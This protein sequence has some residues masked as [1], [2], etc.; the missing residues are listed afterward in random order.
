MSNRKRNLGINVRVTEQ[1]KKRITRNA[2]RCG[3]SSS[4]YLR[5]L[6]SCHSPKAIPTPEIREACRMLSELVSD[7]AANY[8]DAEFQG[9]L[10]Y[11]LG[12]LLAFC[13]PKEG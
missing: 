6:G 8:D 5:Q 1:E 7:Y 12:E 3:L 9:Y 11:A 10:K 13:S 2:K 4:E